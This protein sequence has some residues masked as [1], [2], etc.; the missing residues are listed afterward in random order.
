MW[1]CKWALLALLLWPDIA[2][3]EDNRSKVASNPNEVEVRL[4]D[5][6]RVRMLMLQESLD[7]ET[8]YGKLIT[9]TLD[10]RRIEFGIRPAAALAKR[11]DDAV[12]RLGDKLFQ[13]REKAV[14][15]LVAV[16]APA[17][18]VLHKAARSKD[19]E[20]SQ[21]AKQA[22]EQLRRRIPESR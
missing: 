14:D 4:A 19:P 17:Y 1:H 15:E 12:K 20:V 13:E 16:G 18:L 7:I 9:P 11:I 6:S 22:L 5:G 21:R 2:P 3:A 8:K 10:L